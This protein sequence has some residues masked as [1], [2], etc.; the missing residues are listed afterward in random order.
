[1][2]NRAILHAKCHEC[3]SNLLAEVLEYE[4]KCEN[5][6]VDK[7]LTTEFTTE[8]EDSELLESGAE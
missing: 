6:E 7:P 4:E 5:I 2:G 1:M 8:P 3:S